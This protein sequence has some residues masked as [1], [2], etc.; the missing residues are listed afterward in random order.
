M[1]YFMSAAT[2][3]HIATKIGTVKT[4]QSK[5]RLNGFRTSL[6]PVREQMKFPNVVDWN[7]ANEAKSGRKYWMT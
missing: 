3:W 6:L 5:N 1:L 4:V 2:I 7:I